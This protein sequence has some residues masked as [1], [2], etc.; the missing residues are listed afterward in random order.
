M[1]SNL[2][3]KLLLGAAV[4]ALSFGVSQGAFAAN[5][6]LVDGD[7][8]GSFTTTGPD[9]TADTNIDWD[10][11]T[12]GA[13]TAVASHDLGVVASGTIDV[14]ADT[15]VGDSSATVAGIT[16]TVT[17]QTLTITN[18]ANNGATETLTVANGI[19]LAS[20][21]AALNVTVN[22][23]TG[24][25]TGADVFAL[26]INGDV[27]LGTGTLTFDSDTNANNAMTANIFGNVTAN[28]IVLQ[29]DG[30]PIT[31]TFDGTSAQTVSST[32]NG[33]GDADG[34]MTIA[35]ASGV[36]FSGIIG[37]SQALDLITVAAAD[38]T[39]SAATFTAATSATA[40]VLGNGTGSDTNT[41]TFDGTTAGFTVAGTINGTANDTDN[42]VVT[43]GNTITT[44][45]IIGGVSGLQS[46][47]LTTT[48][49]KLTAS[50]DVTA[51]TVSIASGTTLDL[52]D[53]LIAS[54]A[55]TVASG[56]TLDAG[57]DSV[58]ATGGIAN[59]GTILVSGTGGV[60]ADISGT[61]L[62]DVNAS[63]TVDGVITQGTADIAG[64]TL[65]QGTGTDNYTVGTTNFSADGTIAFAA[66]AKT[67][68][69][70]FTAT[71]DGNGTITI[72]DNASTTAIVGN[73]GTSADAALKALTIAGGAA[74]VTTTTGNLFVDAITQNAADTLQFIGTSGQ[75]V[76]GT[77]TGGIV[78]VGNGTDASDVTFNG[79]AGTIASANVAANSKATMNANFTTTGTY[80][81]TAGATTTVNTGATLTAATLT[82]T[83][84]YVLGV[85]DAN[86]TLAAADFG[87]LT[88]TGGAAATLTASNLSINVNG[89]IGTGTVR[90]LTH[91]NTGAATLADNSIQYTFV[92]ANNGDDT[93]VTVTRTSITD[94]AS[95]SKVT[96]GAG[97]TLEELS[98]S[99]DTQI[100]AVIDNI[101]AASSQEDVDDILESVTPS[102]DAGAVTGATS[103]TTSTRNVTNT[104]LASLRDG[105]EAS[106]MYA[107]NVTNGLRGWVQGFGQTGDQDVRDGVAG[108]DVDSYGIAV[109]LDTESL[110]ENWIWGVAFAYADTEVDS[111]GVNNTKTDIDSYQVS[112]YG[113]YDLDDRTYIAGQVGYVWGDNDQTRSNVGGVNGLTA[114]SDYDSNVY[115]ASLEAGRKYMVGGNTV[116]TPKAL[117]NYQYY[118]A[119]GYTE[120]GAGGANLTTSGDDLDLFEIGVGVDASWDYQQADGSY[121]QPKIGVGVRHDLVGDEYQTSS[122]FQAGGS[123]FKT[124]GFDPAQ[125]TFNVSAGLTYFSTTNW[126]LSAGY[127]FE[128]KSDYD[129]HAG[130]LKAAY[131][132]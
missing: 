103:F 74:N 15:T 72:A 24:D 9:E 108:Y 73:L 119:D 14:N 115:F 71:T 44:S 126:E 111:D 80:T 88:D 90:L 57:A 107:G 76:S 51:A 43:G 41:I 12:N 104:Q 102:V 16:A 38:G 128:Y 95:G 122:T 62:L 3:T 50:A 82:D 45:G 25:N 65:T 125:T 86:G 21:I 42:M 114:T 87:S 85:T 98:A 68:T 77:I 120:T 29:D 30:A 91:I 93:D 94:L 99:T 118:D 56:G 4:T 109:G 75:T 127:D 36:T 32:I 79:V 28:A 113:N 59:S 37:G 22:G 121:L 31:L 40:I 55:V 84:S 27:N 18:D 54:G 78:T 11:G 69:G 17:G 89:D 83:G 53:K 70:D 117:V 35:N 81:N 13:G 34:N 6:F 132:F 1:K 61:G 60:S 2:K 67:I 8:S 101:A 105:T 116:L 7:D 129:S 123:S 47:A 63:A 106:G 64:V 97:A 33:Q 5:E 23:Q 46:L 130:K 19:G 49:T 52:D 96:A 48:G 112:L 10:A 66:G 92:T 131:K 58:T 124:E 39:N 100:A 20:G 110:A 26:D